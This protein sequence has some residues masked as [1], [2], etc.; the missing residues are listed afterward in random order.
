MAK[1]AGNNQIIF[2]AAGQ[3]FGIDTASGPTSSSQTGTINSYIRA[4]AI[5]VHPS[6]ATWAVTITNQ[7]GSIAWTQQGADARGDTYVGP[8]YFKGAVLTVANNTTRVIL[9]DIVWVKY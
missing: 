5:T 3:G 4:E 1:S 9:Q 2:D 7:D 6:A 8:F